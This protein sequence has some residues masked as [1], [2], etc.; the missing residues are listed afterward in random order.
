MRVRIA[1]VYVKKI[2]LL[3]LLFLIESMYAY[4]YIYTAH[5]GVRPCFQVWYLLLFG[6]W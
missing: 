6:R 4:I 3:I 2:Y 1:H 5:V